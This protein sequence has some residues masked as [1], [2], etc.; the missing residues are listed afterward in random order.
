MINAVGLANP[1]LAAVR[2]DDLLFM[3]KV[4]PGTRMIVNVVG[5]TVEEFAEVVG[6]LAAT[7][8]I[9]AFELN[10]SCPNVKHGGL[11]FGADPESLTALVRGVRAT[12]GRPLY[13]KLSPT[14]GQR[15][16]GHGTRCR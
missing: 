8:G 5:N 4:H 9:D 6:G 16:C 12:T 15:H 7:S 10:V 14:L 11:E 3:P 1:G 13:V 2:D